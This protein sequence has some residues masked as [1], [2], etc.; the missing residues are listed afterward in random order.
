MSLL[1]VKFSSVI[2]VEVG[3]FLLQHI[4]VWSEIP[5]SLI[6]IN[7]WLFIPGVPLKNEILLVSLCAFF[8]CGF[9]EDVGE[10]TRQNRTAPTKCI[11]CTFHI[12]WW[13]EA[14]WG[15][16]VWSQRTSHNR[17]RKAP[18]RNF[19]VGFSYRLFRQTT[20]LPRHCSESK[21]VNE[22]RK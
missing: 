1:H 22:C 2:Y 21:T 16:R 20:T 17:K 18:Q 5:A 14:A 8:L 3:C 13:E 10:I 15:E 19:G 4:G 7:G 6:V 11:L 12:Q 9:L